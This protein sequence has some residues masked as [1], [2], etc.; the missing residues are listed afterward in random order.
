MGKNFLL[1]FKQYTCTKMRWLQFRINHFILTTNSFLY[2]IGKIQSPFCT[3]CSRERE[4]I[5]HL[6]WECGEVQKFLHD[7][8]LFCLDNGKNIDFTFKHFIFGHIDDCSAQNLIMMSLKLYIYRCK[9]LYKNLN[10]RRFTI[11]LKHLYEENKYIA[12]KE[13]KVDEFNTKWISWNFLG[14]LQ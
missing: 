2:K 9:C 4:S 5:I 14:Q 10:V 12:T 1:P 11:E 8:H 6:M 3:F 13:K 7:F